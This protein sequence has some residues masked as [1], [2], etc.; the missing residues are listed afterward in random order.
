M[1]PVAARGC[2]SNRLAAC[3]VSMDI[4]KRQEEQRSEAST[5][6]QDTNGAARKNRIS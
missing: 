2:A 1:A 5:C 4:A 3:E 6:H